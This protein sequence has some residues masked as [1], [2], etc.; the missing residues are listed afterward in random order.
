[1]LLVVEG[2]DRAV[3]FY[4]RHGLQIAEHVDGLVYYR[5]RMGVDFPPSTRPFHLVL[6]RQM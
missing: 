2:N 6:M 5:E 3:A 1:M 4:Q